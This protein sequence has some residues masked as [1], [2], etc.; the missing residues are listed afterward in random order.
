MLS[1][2]DVSRNTKREII[3]WERL[4]PSLPSTQPTGNPKLYQ[5]FRALLEIACQ[6]QSNPIPCDNPLFVYSDQ[7][8][9]ML[10]AVIQIGY[11]W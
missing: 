10:Q 2:S 8:I 7:V 3:R 11:Y 5:G 1:F 9:I 4:D 6:F